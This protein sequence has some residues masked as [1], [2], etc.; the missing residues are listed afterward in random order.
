MYL[1]CI[2]NFPYGQIAIVIIWIYSY[3]V[4]HICISYTVLCIVVC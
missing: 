4:I 1:S 2:V 3:I